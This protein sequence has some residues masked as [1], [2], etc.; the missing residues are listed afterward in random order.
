M[1]SPVAAE[2][3]FQ[4]AELREGGNSMMNLLRNL[5]Y[6]PWLIKFKLSSSE[7]REI[8]RTIASVEKRTS[9]QVCVVIEAALPF[10]H[11]IRRCTAR[12]RA[13]EVFASQHIWNTERNNGVLFYILFSERNVEIV[14]DR[15]FDGKV[16]A[17]EWE[18]IC[19]NMERDLRGGLTIGAAIQRSIESIGSVASVVFP[20][21]GESPTDGLPNDVKVI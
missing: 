18:N 14:A 10:S 21:I 6:G 4:A 17:E 5:L 8:E 20:G 2:E 13:I 15:G 9:S 16:S 19:L 12:Q 3:D 11:L 1:V 7:R